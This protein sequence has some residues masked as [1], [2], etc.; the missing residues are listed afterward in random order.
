MYT[1]SPTCSFTA[2]DRI[3]ENRLSYFRED[4]GIY[5]IYGPDIELLI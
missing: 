2:T 4:M 3:P 1:I 5:S